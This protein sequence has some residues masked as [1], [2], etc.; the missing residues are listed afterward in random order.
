MF[1][2]YGQAS[3]EQETLL[4]ACSDYTLIQYMCDK[5]LQRPYTDT[6]YCSTVSLEPWLVRAG[7]GF[8]TMSVG[9]FQCVVND[10]V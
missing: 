3:T 9:S 8:M 6:W 10:E 2:A 5:K 1:N 4:I 7:R